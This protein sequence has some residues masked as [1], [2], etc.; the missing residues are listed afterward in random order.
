M[1]EYKLKTSAKDLCSENERTKCLI[2]L[3]QEAYSYGFSDTP[4]YGVLKFLIEKEIFKLTALP[5]SSYTWL[6]LL[7]NNY[8]RNIV[9]NDLR[10]SEEPYNDGIDEGNTKVN[11]VKFSKVQNVHELFRAAKVLDREE[12]REHL[13][14]VLRN[15]EEKKFEEVKDDPRAMALRNQGLIPL[16]NAL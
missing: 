1:R 6:H 8:G 15:M 16:N 11:R 14:Y 12:L 5:D 2:P 4:Q 9:K 7:G 3:C 10:L 13:H